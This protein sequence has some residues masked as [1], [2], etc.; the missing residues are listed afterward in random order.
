[1]IWAADGVIDVARFS[2]G[3]MNNWQTKVFAG[4]T[5]YSLQNLD[6][7]NALRADSSASASG[8]FEQ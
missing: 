8:R 6:G 7:Q 1:M 2:Q 4:E 3:D 5:Y